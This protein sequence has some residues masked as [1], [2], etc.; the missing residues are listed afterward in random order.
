[1]RTRATPARLRWQV[2]LMAGALSA[3]MACS[4][5]AQ[6]PSPTPTLRL[7]SE[8]PYPVAPGSAPTAAMTAPLTAE[9]LRDLAIDAYVYA[10]PMVLMEMTRRHATNVQ[11]AVAGRAPMNQFG[12][13]TVFPDAK[14]TDVAWPSADT[15]H[16]SLWFDV[17][18]EPLIVQVPDAG[19][20]YVLLNVLDM[21]TDS[22]ASRGTRTNGK[23]P[24]TF[25]I[26]GPNWQGVLPPGVD[27]VRSPTAWGWVVGRV[28]TA[29]TNDYQA[30]NQ[31]QAGLTAVPLSQW[32]KNYGFVSNAPANPAW[33]A[34][35]TPAEQVAALDAASYFT[36]FADLV[37]SNPPHANDNPILDRLRRAG[38]GGPQ[39][40][41][42]SRLDPAVQ[43][44]LSE[45]KPIAGRRIADALS[46]LGQEANGWVTVRS[47]IG[48]YG[49]DYLRRAAVAYAGLGASTPED[50]L[51]PVTWVDSKGR[52]LESG[53]DYVLHFEKDQLPPVDGFWSLTLYDARQGFADNT[54]NRY[55]VRSTDPLK[56]N[57]DGS[58]DIY[59]Q[60]DYP[61]DSKA[62]NWLP[63][64]RDGNVM[65][66]LRLYAPRDIALDGKWAPPAV[67]KD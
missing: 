41:V 38:I 25:A 28:Q 19:N 54:A 3:G 56:Y 66:N 6:T 9:E 14:S 15:L 57:S 36:L 34:Q 46:T 12:H 31:F 42:F 61:G 60:R 22:F 16:S 64:P 27:A 30:V 8:T 35:G 4:V 53:K 23:G 59:I 2:I 62:N 32:G 33:N 40:F 17:S 45:A 24:Q 63:S 10:Y 44:A 20:R 37:R 52:L 48:T 58:L 18:R 11:S 50:V 39:P 26:V 7:V 1:M 29:G 21:W 49:T 5:S 51:Y 47:G 55:S 43:Q 13:R 65:L 67:K